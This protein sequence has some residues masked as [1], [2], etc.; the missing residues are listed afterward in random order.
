MG[1]SHEGRPP[2]Q[3]EGRSV[4]PASLTGKRTRKPD[5]VLA[6]T[7]QCPSPRQGVSD[8][9]T[10]GPVQLQPPPPVSPPGLCTSWGGERGKGGW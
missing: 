3:G 6:Q 10:K 7:V 8:G 4:A 2:G 5:M 1:S 9:E